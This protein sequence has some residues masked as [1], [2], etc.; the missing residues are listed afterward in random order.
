LQEEAGLRVGR[1]IEP[2]GAFSSCIFAIVLLDGPVLALGLLK[3]NGA[4]AADE[5]WVQLQ[6]AFGP[7]AK[8][9]SRS[10]VTR[11]L[12][13]WWPLVD[14]KGVFAGGP[15]DLGGNIRR[16]DRDVPVVAATQRVI[17]GI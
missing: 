5:I 11:H 9:L 7:L 10:R 6:N 17:R 12:G 15:P 3:A 8:W 16:D 1:V 2:R 4:L 14:D 13:G